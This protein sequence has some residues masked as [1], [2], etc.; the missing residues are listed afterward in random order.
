MDKHVEIRKFV[1]ELLDQ[2]GFA[3]TVENR[4]AA[5]EGLQLAW[6]D[7][8]VESEYVFEKIL[9]Q[10][11]LNSTIFSTKLEIMFPNVMSTLGRA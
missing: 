11:A 4:L 8:E 7:T 10:Q 6:E 2:E 3:D 5:L 9:W 1:A